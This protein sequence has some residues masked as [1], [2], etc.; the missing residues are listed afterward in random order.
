MLG[1]LVLEVTGHYL[2]RK[3]NKTKIDKKQSGLALS[4]SSMVKLL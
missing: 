4:V 2:I 3:D 1:L